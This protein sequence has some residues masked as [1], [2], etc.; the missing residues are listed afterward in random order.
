VQDNPA[1]R[2]HMSDAIL[3]LNSPDALLPQPKQPGYFIY[4]VASHVELSS[5]YTI[6]DATITIVEA[7]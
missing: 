7:R 1:D 2:P 6:Q 5:S 4:G 3:M